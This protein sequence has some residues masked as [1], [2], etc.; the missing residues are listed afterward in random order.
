MAAVP[1]DSRL[2]RWK[3]VLLIYGEDDGIAFPVFRAPGKE[4]ESRAR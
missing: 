3:R 2:S 4:L 1:M